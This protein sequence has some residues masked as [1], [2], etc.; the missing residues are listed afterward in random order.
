MAGKPEIIRGKRQAW[1]G[2]HPR[3]RRATTFRTLPSLCGHR[4]SITSLKPKMSLDSRLLTEDDLRALEHTV[5]V[6]HRL[7]EQ[8]EDLERQSETATLGMWLFLATEVMFFGT[9]FTALG[10][11]RFLY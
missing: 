3:R 8:Y 6:R 10:I 2:R 7:E 1:S 4:I 9:L 11:Y 5:L